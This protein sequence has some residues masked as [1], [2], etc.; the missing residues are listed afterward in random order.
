[1]S[2]FQFNRRNFLKIAG[3]TGLAVGVGAAV[4]HTDPIKAAPPF[5]GGGSS[6]DMDAM[7]EAGVKAFLDNI[8]KEPDFWG[9]LM[10]YKMDGATKVFDVT[11][12]EGPWDIAT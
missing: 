3:A 4:S 6:D 8:G 7:H 2:K 9:K 12:T 11:C 10:P 1:M 5:Q